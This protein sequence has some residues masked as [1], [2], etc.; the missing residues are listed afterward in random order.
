MGQIKYQN[1]KYKGQNGSKQVTKIKKVAYE[2]KKKYKVRKKCKK[3]VN[4]SNQIPK[5]K[6]HRSKQ[7]TQLKSG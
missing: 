6:M 4:W 5:Y 3:M 7:V 2:F 1:I